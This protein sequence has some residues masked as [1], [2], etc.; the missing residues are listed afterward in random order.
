MRDEA[1]DGL[2]NEMCLRV[3]REG[4]ELRSR[5][6][7]VKRCWQV[8]IEEGDFSMEGLAGQKEGRG[9][10]GLNKFKGDNFQNVSRC[11]SLSLVLL[12]G[13][14]A[15]SGGDPKTRLNSPKD[16]TR[17]LAAGPCGGY[18]HEGKRGALIHIDLDLC[19]MT[20]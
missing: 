7:A 8:P 2:A 6:F 12:R 10:N 17:G 18:L 20:P 11:R 5:Q 14:A 4:K 9:W 19:R 3:W 13:A 15:L 1:E 16:R